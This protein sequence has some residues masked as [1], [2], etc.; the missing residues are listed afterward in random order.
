MCG[1]DRQ[2]NLSQDGGFDK[3]SVMKQMRDKEFD[4]S[5][6]VTVMND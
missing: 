4:V 2:I 3:K 1:V 5:K 6:E